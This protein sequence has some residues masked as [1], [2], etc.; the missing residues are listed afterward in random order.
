MVDLSMA[1]C[2]CHNQM[3]E[4]C[5]D[6]RKSSLDPMRNPSWS[7]WEVMTAGKRSVILR[8]L[9]W[10]HMEVCFVHRVTQGYP[11]SSSISRWD[12]SWNQPLFFWSTPIYGN[13]HIE[14]WFT[15]IRTIKNRVAIVDWFSDL[16]DNQEIVGE[17]NMSTGISLIFLEY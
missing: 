14:T 15:G 3:V 9:G 12:V 7:W 2:E 11:I 4:L 1:N 16:T 17:W 8:T 6:H 5:L 10:N 13:P